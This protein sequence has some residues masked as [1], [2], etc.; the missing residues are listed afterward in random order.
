MDEKEIFDLCKGVFKNDKTSYT[1]FNDC[2]SESL[3]KAENRF[4]L[5]PDSGHRWATPMELAAEFVK[6]HFP[7]RYQELWEDFKKESKKVDD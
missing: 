2:D 1:Y 6:E 7:D 3:D 5:L 4:G